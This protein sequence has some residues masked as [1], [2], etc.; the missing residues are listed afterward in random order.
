MKVSRSQIRKVLIKEA[1]SSRAEPE[2][3]NEA[4]QKERVRLLVRKLLSEMRLRA[5]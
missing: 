3:M 5:K 4:D 2:A 1:L